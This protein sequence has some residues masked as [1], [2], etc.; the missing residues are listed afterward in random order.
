MICETIVKKLVQTIPGLSSAR[1]LTPMLDS[2]KR[3]KKMI[4]D[5]R[6]KQKLQR[7]KDARNKV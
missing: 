6:H 1:I 5:F 2:I 7:K 4:K 3:K